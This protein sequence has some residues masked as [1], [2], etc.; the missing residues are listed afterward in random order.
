VLHPGKPHPP[1]WIP[2]GT[3]AHRLFQRSLIPTQIARDG[4]STH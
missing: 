1:H 3:F 2:R 4:A